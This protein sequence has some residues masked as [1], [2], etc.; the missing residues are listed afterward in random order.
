MNEEKNKPLSHLQILGINVG[1]FA[2]YMIPGFL[3]G[4]GI[5]MSAMV[6]GIHVIVCTILAIVYKNLTWFLS[7]LLIILISFGTCVAWLSMG[8]IRVQ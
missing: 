3:N 5:I 7:G 4:D 8:G 2:L 6:M 1:I